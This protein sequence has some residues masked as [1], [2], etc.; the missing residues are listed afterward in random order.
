MHKHSSLLSSMLLLVA[1]LPNAG[2]RSGPP[3][4]EDSRWRLHTKL[5]RYT[6]APGEV[7]VVYSFVDDSY[8]PNR[9]LI[10]SEY[11][12]AQE[13]AKSN[14]PGKGSN[15]PSV[16]AIVSIRRPDGSE[17]LYSP[18]GSRLSPGETP[19]K[20]YWEAPVRI[21]VASF[22]D[23]NGSYML[24]VTVYHTVPFYHGAMKSRWLPFQVK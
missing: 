3:P 24:Q 20:G 12:I 1:L 15:R 8:G 13:V 11:A 7:L 2:C 21:P 17:T 5:A 16:T 19:T 23:G 4:I 9:S 10:T 18:D 22:A 14:K 6:V